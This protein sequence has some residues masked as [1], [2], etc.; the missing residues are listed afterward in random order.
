MHVGISLAG[1]ATMVLLE[2]AGGYGV[3][4]HRGFKSAVGMIVGGIW[5][6]IR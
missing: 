5:S 1:S 3:M 4:S 2:Q 6:A